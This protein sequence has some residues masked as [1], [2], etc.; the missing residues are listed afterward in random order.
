MLPS[1]TTLNPWV[2]KKGRGMQPSMLVFQSFEKTI[3][4]NGLAETFSSCSFILRKSFDL[5]IAFQWFF[6]AMATAIFK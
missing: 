4:S 1:E 2:Y 6:V 5:S 3:Y